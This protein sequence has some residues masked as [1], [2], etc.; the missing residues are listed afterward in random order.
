MFYIKYN[1]NKKII[2]FEIKIKNEIC[3]IFNYLL[4]WREEHYLDKLLAF[5]RK[6]FYEDDSTVI[7]PKEFEA[8]LPRHSLIVGEELPHSLLSNKKNMKMDIS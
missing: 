8:L 6:R 1:Y 5:F 7:K 3:S 2:D 4:D